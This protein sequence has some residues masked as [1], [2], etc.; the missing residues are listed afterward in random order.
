[1][2]KFSYYPTKSDFT[3]TQHTPSNPT[4][5]NRSLHTKG[6]KKKGEKKEEK[7]TRREQYATKE[8]SLAI[9]KG[10]T[11]HPQLPQA[12]FRP[13]IPH[14]HSHIHTSIYVGEGDPG[15][16]SSFAIGGSELWGSEASS[17]GATGLSS[18]THTY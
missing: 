11:A 13:F 12:G 5:H 9:T 18:T 8:K 15:V 6:H 2:H 14:T 16:Y 4:K 3:Q 10:K 17:F 1:L 7:K